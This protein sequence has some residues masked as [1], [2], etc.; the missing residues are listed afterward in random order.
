MDY[1]VS[2]SSPLN[3]PLCS[4][5]SFQLSVLLAQEFAYLLFTN[6]VT[7]QITFSMRYSVKLT[8]IHLKPLNLQRIGDSYEL[9][10]LLLIRELNCLFFYA[11]LLGC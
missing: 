6:I 9:Q 2:L 5:G 11:G 3:V 4:G 10:N 1:N 8:E 7:V